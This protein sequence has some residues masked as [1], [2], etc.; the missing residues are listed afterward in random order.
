M[1]GPGSASPHIGG[2][3]GVEIGNDVLFGPGI[4][5]FSENHE[6]AAMDLLIREQG[7]RRSRVT[8]ADDCWFGARV[9]ILWLA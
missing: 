4:R 2:R 8:I 7:E 1:I 6:F 9:T 5:I 3:G